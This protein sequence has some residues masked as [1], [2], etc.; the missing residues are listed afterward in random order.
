MASWL[1]NRLGFNG[2]PPEGEPDPPSDKAPIQKF[3]WWDARLDGL[4]PDS[5]LS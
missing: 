4:V 5:K 2:P 3:L 1:P